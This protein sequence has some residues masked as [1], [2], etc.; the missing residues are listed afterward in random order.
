MHALGCMDGTKKIMYNG[1]EYSV[2]SF[3]YNSLTMMNKIKMEFSNTPDGLWGHGLRESTRPTWAGQIYY[4][5]SYKYNTCPVYPLASGYSFNI[6]P[7]SRFT[8]ARDY[9]SA[10]NKDVGWN[11]V[12]TPTNQ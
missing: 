9:K 11:I 4:H 12:L 8:Y 5:S 2:S 3:D 1:I 6:P 10:S 7:K